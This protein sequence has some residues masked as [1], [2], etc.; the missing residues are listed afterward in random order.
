[1]SG[2]IRE[3]PFFTN[4]VYTADNEESFKIVDY[5]NGY[6]NTNVITD[7]TIVSNDDT[8][9]GTIEITRYNNGGI[10]YTLRAG[11]ISITLIDNSGPSYRNY[12]KMARKNRKSRNARRN[13][14]NYSRRI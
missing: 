14:R 11:K 3:T 4:K 12:R 6:D 5:S 8:I 7:V 1:M 10:E 2:K 13:R 9:Y